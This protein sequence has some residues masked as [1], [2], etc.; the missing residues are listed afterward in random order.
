MWLPAAEAAGC[1]GAGFHDLRRLNA[2]TLVVGGVDVKTAQVRL[3]HADP[4]ITLAI[5]ASAPPST[6]RA[7]AN[8]LGESLFGENGEERSG[9]GTTGIG[10]KS[11]RHF[12]AKPSEE[13]GASD[14]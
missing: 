12:R 11:P 1:K 10:T 7:A 2:A 4:R 9:T 6:D 5:Y 13:T 14:S 3:G 8:V